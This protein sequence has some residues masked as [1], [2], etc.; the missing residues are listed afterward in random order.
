MISTRDSAR[1]ALQ[2]WRGHLWKVFG[3]GLFVLLAALLVVA[4]RQT[5]RQARLDVRNLGLALEARLDSGLLQPLHANLRTLA[6]RLSGGEV[7]NH[8]LDATLIRR[9]HEEAAS[10]PSQMPFELIDEKGRL[11][12]SSFDGTAAPS[13][14]Q[15]RYWSLLARQ[16][17]DG[18]S[19]VIEQDPNQPRLH[20]AIPIF[21]RLGS[22]QG[23]VATSL[24]LATV[25]EL[26]HEVDVGL[27]G[28]ISV[29][30]VD[31]PESVLRDPPL[32]N[33]LDPQERVAL[34]EQHV[35]GRRDGDFYMR[36]P[37][38]GIERLYGFK[39]I[40]EYPLA[41]TIG[42]ATDDY[43][44]EWHYTFGWACA[45]S[46]VFF[47][48]IIS[49]DRRLH[50]AQRRESRATADL[51]FM[52]YHDAL[53][54]LPNRHRI[55]E[56]IE[57]AIVDAEG[58][59][60]LYLDLD[61]FKTIN[62]SLG[63]VAGDQVLCEL[64]QRLTSL[65]GI[66]TTARLG[67]D[68]YLMLVRAT[69]RKQLEQLLR[70]LDSRLR[71]PWLVHN[72]LLEVRT[73][74]GI[75]CHPDHGTSFD[76]LFKAAD[77]ALNQ[78]KKC[79]RA[80]H[81]FYTPAMGERAL[82][83]LQLQVELRAALHNDE[84]ELH[85]QPQVNLDSGEVVGAEALLR[86]RHP[87]RGMI[88]PGEFIAEAES[89]GLIVPIGRWLLTTACEQAVA[90]QR[91]GLGALI[92]AVNCSA[93]EFKQGDYVDS[94]ALALSTS[95]LESSLLELELTESILIEDTERMIACFGRLK[96]MGV[97]LAIDDFGTGYSSMAYLKHLTI[98]RLKIDRSFVQNLADNADDRAIVG[99]MVTLAHNL[100]LQIVAEGVE[101]D[102]VLPILS[103]MGCDEAQGYYFSRPVP[104]KE[105]EL[106]MS[107]A[108]GTV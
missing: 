33:P 17:Q 100:N 3:C 18:D 75:T 25:L 78:A 68:E 87:S 43:R 66:D 88:Y 24:N 39:R 37:L 54:G 34:D 48:V 85:Y 59:H 47:L 2:T 56:R 9:F 7:S 60:L 52:A 19:L 65:Q 107:S 36:S 8:G 104:V 58:F 42:L 106:F 81:T 38:D 16:A 86:W 105:F 22:R 20:F 1:S 61:N 101:S 90:W 45:L 99:T 27:H 29:R 53:T 80:R 64:A 67:G 41:L 96:A 5:E 83:S 55:S 108:L 72:C 21:D 10:L 102:N 26:F 15:L 94:V 6:T 92:V 23:W 74:I 57:E 93:I 30:R 14:D 62:D 50:R 32:A 4:Y 71:E 103:R 82:K 35:S 95:G 28:V 31:R 91:M 69:T 40:G 46:A 11:V 12:A 44:K 49:L 89:S 73:S 13:F 97:R 51:A 76:D 63:H 70:D 77:I 84:F 98:D 79:G